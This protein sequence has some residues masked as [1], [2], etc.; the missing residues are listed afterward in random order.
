MWT[1]LKFNFSM[2]V[3]SP[4]ISAYLLSSAY[5]ILPKYGWNNS[6]AMALAQSGLKLSPSCLPG[7]YPQGQEI[8]LI[9]H[10]RNHLCH[11]YSMERMKTFNATKPVTNS[12]DI[13]HINEEFRRKIDVLLE[14][15][16]AR[17]EFISKHSSL[18]PEALSILM[19]SSTAKI[20]FKDPFDTATLLLCQSDLRFSDLEWYSFRAM[21]VQVLLSIEAMICSFSSEMHARDVED[22]KI[23]IK[24]RLQSYYLSK[25]ALSMV[26]TILSYCR[27]QA[28]LKDSLMFGSNTF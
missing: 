16:Y 4:N 11:D 6:I 3:N 17:T 23:Y 9:S 2:S 18:W 19:R 15:L 5:Q 27:S 8:A 22:L 21:L 14:G 28:M 25:H 13:D 24:N 20:L 7:I 26:W 10:V 12:M 1:K